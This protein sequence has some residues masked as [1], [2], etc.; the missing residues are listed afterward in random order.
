MINKIVNKSTNTEVITESDNIII[1]H[2]NIT[3]IS[4]P[5]IQFYDLIFDAISD[6]SSNTPGLTRRRIETRVVTAARM[7]LSL[8][9]T[10]V[11]GEENDQASKKEDQI[12]K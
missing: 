9:N 8:V 10:L 3:I 11:E 6:S 4:V 5:V 2:N 12:I 1:R 7:M